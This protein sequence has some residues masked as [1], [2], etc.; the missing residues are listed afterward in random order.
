MKLRS[1]VLL[2]ALSLPVLVFADDMSAN[3]FAG[4]FAGVGAGYTATRADWSDSSTGTIDFA[5]GSATGQVLAGYNY[6]IN[7]NWLI[8]L[9]GYFNVAPSRATAYSDE[10]NDPVL[11]L[12]ITPVYG[13]DALLGYS[14]NQA[15]MLFA[16][17]GVVD[18]RVEVGAPQNEDL[19]S[20]SNHYTG[21]TG[22]LG[23]QEALT[24]SFS[25]RE[26]ISYA[27]YTSKNELEGTSDAYSFKPVQTVG[28]ISCIYTFAV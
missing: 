7:A 2:A 8:G 26:A 6:G 9:Q 18:A 25:L 4:V 22:T 15:A 24:G 10:N 20:I 23:A 27:S 13:I 16:G 12:K 14:L 1:L 3:P 21:W 19:I 28:M 11:T 5:Q 17:F